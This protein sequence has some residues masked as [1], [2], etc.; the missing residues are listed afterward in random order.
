MLSIRLSRTGKKN[1][2]S[3]RLIV[4]EKSKDPWGTFLEILGHYNPRIEAKI[5][6]LNEERLKYWIGKGAQLSATVNNLLVTAGVIN[7]PKMKVQR[8]KKT[9]GAEAEEAKAAE[10]AKA[11][12]KAAALAEAAKPEA[13]KA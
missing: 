8:R 1:Q 9:K 7:K 11:A 13:P 10:A 5:V 2:P 6:D 12:A 3:Y 4:S